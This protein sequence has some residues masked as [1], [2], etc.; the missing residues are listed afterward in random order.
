MQPQIG[1]MHHKQGGALGPDIGATPGGF[2]EELVHYVLQ[3][4]S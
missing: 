4:T 1:P 3:I 2:C